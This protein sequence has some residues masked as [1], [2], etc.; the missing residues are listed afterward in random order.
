MNDYRTGN[1]E[2][3]KLKMINVINQEIK[4]VNMT[5]QKYKNKDKN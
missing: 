2:Y 5:I 3:G 4:I 1:N